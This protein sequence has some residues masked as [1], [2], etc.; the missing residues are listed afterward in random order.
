ME[1]GQGPTM[2][3]T[4]GGDCPERRRMN[5]G[6]R[7]DGRGCREQLAGL[8]SAVVWGLRVGWGEHPHLGGHLHLG[9]F[10]LIRG[11]AVG[12]EFFKKACVLWERWVLGW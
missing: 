9:G 8:I 3:W 2:A 10:S 7:E 12:E 11:G 4:V 5:L 6:S 1:M